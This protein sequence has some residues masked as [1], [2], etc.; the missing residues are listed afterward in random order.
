MNRFIQTPVKYI[1]L[2]IW[3]RGKYIKRIFIKIFIDSF[4]FFPETFPHF[5]VFRSYSNHN[6][7]DN[8]DSIIKLDWIRVLKST[9]SYDYDNWICQFVSQIY[10]QCTWLQFQELAAKDSY[11]AEHSLIPLI[12][13]LL[14]CS[15]QQHKNDIVKMLEY[16][17][18]TFLRN[19]ENQGELK[20]VYKDKRVI[21]MI[22]NVCECIR[23][24]NNW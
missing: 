18:D 9:E 24:N 20:R 17:F 22:L 8:Y 10:K 1:N 15:E 14:Q 12:R 23:I 4:T 3:N 13:L 19:G 7:L 2:F 5:S 6:Y 21:N 11:F 16:F